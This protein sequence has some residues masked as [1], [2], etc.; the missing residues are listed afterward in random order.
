MIYPDFPLDL[1]GFFSGKHLI[2]ILANKM[3]D[4]RNFI[5]H[6]CILSFDAEQVYLVTNVKKKLQQTLNP[7]P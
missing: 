1:I 7:K 4:F 6:N 5:L 3:Q 2:Q